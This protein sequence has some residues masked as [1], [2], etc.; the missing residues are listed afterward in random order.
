MTSKRTTTIVT[1]L[2]MASLL[3]FAISRH[4]VRRAEPASETG[5]EGAIYT[6]LEAARAGDVSAYLSQYS[7]PMASTLR[8]VVA[9][10]SEAGFRDYLRSTNAEVKGIAVSGVHQVSNSE[11][12]LQLEYVFQD[13]NEVQSVKLERE[14]DRWKIVRVDSAERVK[15]LVPYGT[16]VP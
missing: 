8:A 7:G 9:E 13:R 11:A 3:A 4:S 15:T 16:P 1:A 12:E 5:P 14:R 6:M 10:K 2:V